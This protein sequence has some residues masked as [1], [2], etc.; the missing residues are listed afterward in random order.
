MLKANQSLL[1][2]HLVAPSLAAPLLKNHSAFCVPAIRRSQPA[3]LD[4]GAGWLLVSKSVTSGTPSIII[5][6]A[7]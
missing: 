3:C 2:F 7:I 5:F 4:H 1:L 6:G